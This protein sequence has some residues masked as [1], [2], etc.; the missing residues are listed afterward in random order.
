MGGCGDRIR[1]LTDALRHPEH[2]V[3]FAAA[4]AILQLDPRQPFNGASDLMDVIA[5]TISTHGRRK[6]LIIHNRK[7]QADQLLGSLSGL[8]FDA[9]VA[10]NGKQAFRIA[11]RD[12]D[13]ELIL[14]SETVAHPRWSELLQQLQHDYHTKGIPLCLIAR[15]E[16]LGL[17]EGTALGLDGV[18]SFPIPHDEKTMASLMRQVLPLTSRF[19]TTSDDRMV[20]ANQALEL[21]RPIAANRSTYS[22]Y[23]LLPYESQLINSLSVSQLAANSARVIG[24]LGTQAAQSALLDMAGQSFRDVNLRKVAATEFDRS[25]QRSGIMLKHRELLAQYEQYNQVLK[26]D[27][28]S[29]EVLSSILDSIEKFSRQE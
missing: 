10:S 16:R 8:G 3:R 27:E 12:P 15:S 29:A 24:G 4:K 1:T 26:H 28:A 25:I 22:F 14:L 21:L 11:R 18:Q 2:R 6:V 7:D 19:A 23:E 13:I 5:Q 17:A 20:M 9:E